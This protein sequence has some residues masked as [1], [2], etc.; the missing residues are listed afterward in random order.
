LSE[1]EGEIETGGFYNSCDYRIRIPFDSYRN[2]D[3]MVQYNE[4]EREREIE[5]ER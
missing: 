1:R 2:I 5:R 4:K 3:L